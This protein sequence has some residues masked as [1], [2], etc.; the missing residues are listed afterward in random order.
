MAFAKAVPERSEPPPEGTPDYGW[1]DIISMFSDDNGNTWHFSDN[2]IKIAAHT[3]NNTRY[4]GV[5]PALIELTDGRIWMLIRTRLGHLYES[6][7]L[8][9]GSSW[10]TPIA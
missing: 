6:Y 9:A 10:Q 1:N 3:P 4:G 8:D 7:S 5:E 2:N